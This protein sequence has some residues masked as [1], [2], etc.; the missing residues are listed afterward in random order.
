M[1]LTWQNSVEFLE[2][3]EPVDT[4][5]AVSTPVELQEELNER[6][7]TWI[8][9]IADGDPAALDALYDDSSPRLF[10]LLVH[11]LSSKALAENVL[12]AVYEEIKVKARTYKRY[13]GSAS[14]WL[15]EIT[16]SAA[17]TQL[18]VQEARRGLSGSLSLFD[19]SRGR[20]RAVGGLT[21]LQRRILEMTYFGGMAVDEA[22]TRLNLSSDI[23]RQ[24]IRAGMMSLRKGT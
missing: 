24:E 17:L 19:S 22:A 15:V 12:T 2:V 4:A 3:A 5:E 20:L 9:G 11:M 6:W 10:G 13:W 7:E 8:N 23:I 21:E 14:S 1:F 18:H 16:R